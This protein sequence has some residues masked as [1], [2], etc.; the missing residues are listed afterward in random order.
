M[1]DAIIL[2]G[3]II[4]FAIAAPV[5]PIGVLCI[6]RSLNRGLL[7][8]LASG[9]GAA[10]A[11]AVYGLIA[12]FGLTLISDFFVTQQ[13]PLRLAGG[14]FLLYLGAKLFLKAQD[15]SSVSS[16]SESLSGAYLSTFFLTLT[17]PMTILSFTL[18]FAGAG[19]ADTGGDYRSAGLLVLGVF[20]GSAAWWFLLSVGSSYF[21]DR[22]DARK[23]R[24]VNRVAGLVVA[25]FGGVILLGQWVS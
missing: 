19:I 2:Q 14:I 3:M 5:G 22:M 1:S 25:G 10:S 24:W 7:Y 17:N 15:D 6:Q 12:A 18:I 13:T 4:G 11:D 9:L 20:L 8:G 16:A 21:Q 23:L